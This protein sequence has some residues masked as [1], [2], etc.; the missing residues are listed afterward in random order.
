MKRVKD[1]L[2]RLQ[3]KATTTT[4]KTHRVSNSLNGVSVFAESTEERTAGVCAQTG[5]AAASS[6]EV[7]TN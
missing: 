1:H 7:A 6:T 4:T 2:L 3:A 5:I